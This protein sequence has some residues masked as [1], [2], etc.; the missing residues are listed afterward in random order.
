MATF[1]HRT[2]FILNRRNI[3]SVDRQVTLLA[4]DGRH[5]LRVRGAQKLSSKLAGSLEPLTL[6][7]VTIVRGRAGEQVVGS[8]IRNSFRLLH[9]SLPLISAASLVA[10]CAN[11]LVRGPMDEPLPFRRIVESMTLLSR[12]KTNR[13]VYLAVSFGL[14][15]LLA[16]LGYRPRQH[17]SRIQT[18]QERLCG[19]LLRGNPSLISRIRCAVKTARA[20]LDQAV[21]AVSDTAEQPVVALRFFRTTFQ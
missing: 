16:A 8:T 15:N 1:T 19:V 20:C 9:V 13:E 12:C 14:W 4:A 2:G 3:G 11:V 18:P 6:V 5:D 7:D 17:R 10:S 21:A